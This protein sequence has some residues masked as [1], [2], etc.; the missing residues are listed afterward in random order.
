MAFGD[1]PSPEIEEGGSLMLPH[2]L[3]AVRRL[4]N[5]FDDSFLG[6]VAGVLAIV[7]TVSILLIISEA[8]Q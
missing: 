7:W 8:L 3:R 6:Q 1:P 2:I 4:S 5:I